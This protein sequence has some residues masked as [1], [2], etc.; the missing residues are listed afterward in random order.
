VDG[1]T[2][3]TI[4]QMVKKPAEPCDSQPPPRPKLGVTVPLANEED[5]IQGFLDRV[6]AHL[7]S[8]DRVYCVLDNVCKDRTRSIVSGRSAQDPRVVLV[9]SP[10]NR[11][12]VDAYFAG[13]RAAFDDGCE[14]ILEMDG[15]FSHLPEQIPPFLAAM[16]QG[17][18]YVGG[19][20][21]LPGGCHKSPWN[22][23][24]VSK[25]GTLLARRLLNAKMTDMTSGFEC[26]NR[27]AMQMVLQ[28]GVASKANFFQTE[29]RWMMHPL[30]WLEVPISYQ[31]ANFRIGRSSIREAFRILWDL[32]RAEKQKRRTA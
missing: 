27:R 5:T 2:G 22:R 20:R 1:W 10:Q 24:L 25:G 30:R 9:W 29:I 12:V 11:C 8:H 26:F 3:K 14:W 4:K 7:L 32:R 28:A 18:D 16:E 13:Y 31:N 6:L 23:V 17:Y 15:G 19:S 21:Y